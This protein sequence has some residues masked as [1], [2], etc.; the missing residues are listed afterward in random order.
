M[1]SSILTAIA[2]LLRIFSNPLANVFQKQLTTKNNHPLLINFLSYFLLS[3]FCLFIAINIQ[4]QDLHQ[5]FWLYSI[6]GGIIGSIGNGF[7]VKALQKGELSVLGPVNAYKSVAGI[8]VAIFLLGEIPNFWGVIGVALIVYGSYFVLDTI[9]EKFSWALLKRMDIQYRIWAMILSA[10]EAVFIKK[11]ILAS[12]PAIAFVSWCWFGAVFS[13]IFLF[14]SRLNLKKEIHKIEEIHLSKYMLLIICIGT[15]QFTTI[16]T[17]NHMP[18]GYALSLFQLSTIVSVFL[19]H[20][21]FKEQ[22]IR[23]KLIGTAI[24]IA[25]SVLIMLFKDY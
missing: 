10:I 23:R 11:V 24:M 16:F 14:I 15:M 4:W 17:F 7:L 3:F 21:F 12:S 5:Q 2:V 8:I 19:G 9:E 18:V 13:L 6:L 20:R 25:G 1:L 22:E